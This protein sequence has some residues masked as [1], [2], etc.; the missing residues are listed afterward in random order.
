MCHKH[1][2]FLRIHRVSVM[3]SSVMRCTMRN[4]RLEVPLHR[5]NL[6][7]KR[8]VTAPCHR[9]S[10]IVALSPRLSRC[11][12]ASLWCV[13]VGIHSLCVNSIQLYYLALSVQDTGGAGHRHRSC[14]HAY[15]YETYEGGQ[16]ICMYMYNGVLVVFDSCFLRLFMSHTRRI[17]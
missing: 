12:C 13:C 3:Y 10:A 14:I 1:F 15:Q 5:V 17:T 4:L 8:S 9:L 7:I 11:L 2:V 6:Y 16:C